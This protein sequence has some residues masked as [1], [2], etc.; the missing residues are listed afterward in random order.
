MSIA[1]D[2]L[3]TGAHL[4]TMTRDVPYG[5][6]RDGAIGISGERIAWVGA[7]RDLPR[8]VRARRTLHVEHA[9]AT[10]GLVDCHTHLVY[11]GSRAN[12]F[13]ARLT[14]ATYADIAQAGGGIKA[15]VEATRAASDEELVA[16]SRPRLAALAGE[17]VT[18]VEI[19]SGYGLDT[20]HECRQLHA[21]RRVAADVGVDVRTTLLA[22]HAVPA[23]FAGRADDYID[24]V[25]RETIPAVAR[26]GLADAVDAFCETIGFTPAQTR[27]V[28]AAARVHGLP[29]KLH[30][31][32]LSDTG[33]AAL[34]AEFG[35]LSADHLEYTSEAGVAA[36]ARAGT[37]AVL[38]PGAY[39]AL[40]ETRAPPIAA[41]RAHS[42]PMAV[43]TDCNP[44]TSP[45]TSL[46]LM[47]NMACTLFR[48]TP[49][50]ALAG[51]TRHAARA[52]GIR[53][54]GTLAVGQ[55]A[56]IAFWNIASPAELACN[57]GGNPCRC[58]VRA[59]RVIERREP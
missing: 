17:G 44:G 25:C 22:A 33:G 14:G 4:A 49:E 53:D 35:A 6:I 26:A 13:E 45:V 15:T 58:V 55:R 36:M 28:F 34:A 52:L 18:T 8:G 29:V 2:L 42:L 3:I 5:V 10:P 7:A 20:V 16:A 48:L 1:H 38:L 43:A 11:A 46:L 50:E 54:R 56:D 41:M 12:E 39:Y 19:K 24:L 32:Q 9:W 40:R 37:I 57:I 27:R 31:D 21:A 59:G 30:A 51:V 47:L 23:E